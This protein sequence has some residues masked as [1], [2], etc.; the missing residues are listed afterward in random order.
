MRVRGGGSF[1]KLISELPLG[2]V[3]MLSNGYGGKMT[4][5]VTSVTR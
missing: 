3:R 5:V 4:N 2:S 1:S